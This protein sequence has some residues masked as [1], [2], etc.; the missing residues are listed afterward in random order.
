MFYFSRLRDM[1]IYSRFELKNYKSRNLSN[2][3]N[4]G[5]G[6]RLIYIY[7]RTSFLRK[8]SLFNRGKN[9]GVPLHLP[10]QILDNSNDILNTEIKDVLIFIMI[11]LQ[12]LTFLCEPIFFKEY[13]RTSEHSNY[14][15]VLLI[16]YFRY[17]TIKQ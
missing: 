12:C 11:S 13:P 2:C 16:S 9:E 3:G 6:C 17:I 7:I 8:H 14:L 10:Q 1:K 4:I 15:I 5:L